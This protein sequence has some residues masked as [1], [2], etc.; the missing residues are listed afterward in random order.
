MF[1]EASV[2]HS[3]HRRGSAFGGLH[4]GGFCIPVSG[5]CMR[6]GGVC[7][8]GIGSLHRGRGS[9]QPLPSVRILVEC[10]LVLH[11]MSYKSCE[12]HWEN[13]KNAESLGRG[14]ACL[15]PF[16]K[17]SCSVMLHARRVGLKLFN[18]VI[19]NIFNKVGTLAFLYLLYLQIS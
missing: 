3:F 14:R 16:L 7:I 5:V 6:E 12:I 11:E 17:P 2:S 10:I 4:P 1:S 13:S 15:F 18:R 8:Q 9:A 19:F